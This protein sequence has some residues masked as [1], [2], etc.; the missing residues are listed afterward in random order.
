MK[1]DHPE[2]D[3][4]A[5]GKEL[6]RRWQALPMEEKKVM[7]AHLCLFED[8]YARSNEFLVLSLQ[9][10]FDMAAQDKIRYER[11]LVVHAPLPR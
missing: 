3:L 7:S 4:A 1:E 2:F 6:G 11:D 9:P 5:V 8:I 10:F